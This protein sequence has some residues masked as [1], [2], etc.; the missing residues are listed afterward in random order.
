VI[1]VSFRFDEAIP[2]AVDLRPSLPL[3][4]F[5]GV[6]P[7][8]PAKT[9]RA[10][11]WKL[12]AP[13]T[14]AWV[15]GILD[16][17][18]QDAFSRFG[19]T[20]EVRIYDPD[21]TIE[22]I[23]PRDTP[24]EL[25]VSERGS[26]LALRMGGF[27]SK[28]TTDAGTTTLKLLAH[29]FWIRRRAVFKTYSSQTVSAILEDLITTLTPLEW[30]PALVSITYDRTLSATW[31]GEYLDVVI[32]ELANGSDGEE[33]GAD[34]SMQFFFRP[35]A[36]NR[37][38]RDFVE[39]EYYDARFSEDGQIEINKATV[40]WGTS[41]TTGAV[42]VQD[43]AAQLALKEKFGAPRAVVIEVVKTYPEITS[44]DEARQKASAI[45]ADRQVIRTGT[46]RTWGGTGIRP[47]DV[48]SVVVPDQQVNGTYRVAQI[49]YAWASG[50]TTV[51]LAENA[52]GVVDVLVELSDEVSRIDAR[53]ADGDAALLE[54]VDLTEEIVT[55]VELRVY[56]RAIPDDMF[57][58]G[59]T[60]AG[61]G[62]GHPD[63]GGG[64]L[65]DRRGDRVQVI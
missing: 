12:Y 43:R 9:E 16:C 29:D 48:C 17:Y 60:G 38:P 7:L 20:A 25:W 46:I 51:K 56:T 64:L 19:R 34:D 58:F 15:P 62:V 22:Q 35:R 61:G 37:S 36:A 41:P 33:W 30:N 53:A 39:G 59:D 28:V 8:F 63:V 54:I 32:A 23:Y 65:G 27:V 55:D 44:E 1:P 4:E 6:R 50:E 10:T 57:V 47:G 14:A 26:P 24:L 11:V 42:S 18:V 21:S 31:K 5:F 45:L 2:L 13:T 52:G 3:S 40:Y 49:E